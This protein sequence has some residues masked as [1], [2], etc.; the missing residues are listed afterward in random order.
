MTPAI[1]SEPYC[2]E[3][4]SR[5]TSTERSIA[6][7]MVF[8]S[9]AA[10]PRPIELFAFTSAAAWRRF[11]FTSTSTWSGAR[12]RSVAGRI[13]S[14]P[15]ARPGRGKFSEGRA[16]DRACATSGTPT[17]RSVSALTTSTGATVSSAER[18]ATRVPVTTTSASSATSSAAAAVSCDQAGVRLPSATATAK[19]TEWG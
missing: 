9:T 6:P 5:S 19:A 3:A 10:E 16:T 4:P 15:S 13:V 7:G 14:V 18:F 17:L 11:E 1:A 2:A 8:R 12:P